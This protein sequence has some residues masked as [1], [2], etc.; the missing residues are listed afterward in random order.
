MTA[1]PL[2]AKDPQSAPDLLGQAPQEVGANVELPPVN[3]GLVDTLFKLASGQ[4][5]ADCAA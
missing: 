4:T 5:A 3:T 2:S 1:T